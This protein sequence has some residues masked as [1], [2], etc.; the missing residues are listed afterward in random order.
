MHRP[1][2]LSIV[3][4][5]LVPLAALAY[6]AQAERRRPETPPSALASAIADIEAGRTTTPLVR[7]VADGGAFEVTFLARSASGIAPR[8]VS[9]ATGWG[10]QPGEGFSFEVG[11]MTPVEGTDARERPSGWHV[12][13]ARLA[14]QARIEY[15]VAYA[16]GDYRVDPYNPRRARF[17]SGSPASELVTPGYV[18]PPGLA[19][20]PRVATG[21]VIETSVESR[22]LAGAVPAVVYT[23][24]GYARG[25]AYPVAVFHDRLHWGR[26]GD[27]PR[28]L[29]WLIARGALEPLVAV[30]VD[31]GRTGD[32]HVPA[33]RTFL[34]EELPRWLAARYGVTRNAGGRAVL[35]VSY[36]AKDALEASTGAVASYARVGLLIPGRRLQPPDIEALAARPGPRLHVVILAG[37]YDTPNLQAA[38]GVR[39]AFAGAGHAVRYIEVPEG[40]NAA[41]W[42]DHAGEVLTALFPP[43]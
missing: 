22:T 26:E 15:L 36:G 43:R 20:S 14:P 10:E 2:R 18:P 28:L 9:D 6:W 19:E 32:E 34:G 33:V 30:F 37:S 3:L 24:P 23:P 35:G 39:T 25:G 4:A 12:L 17:R 16:L 31:S 5:G 29:D 27:G 7:A 41:T 38:R 21:A 8:I 13:V 11:R 1:S 40:H 42:R